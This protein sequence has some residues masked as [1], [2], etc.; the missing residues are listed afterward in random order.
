MSVSM[1]R[2]RGCDIVLRKT[3]Q[4]TWQANIADDAGFSVNT[5]SYAVERDARAEARVIADHRPALKRRV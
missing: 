4:G 5:G 1:E 3:D 2:Y